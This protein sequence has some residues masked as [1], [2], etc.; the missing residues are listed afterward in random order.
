MNYRIDCFLREYEMTV[1]FFLL[2]VMWVLLT[3]I[4]AYSPFFDVKTVDATPAHWF[5]LAL[6]VMLLICAA[7]AYCFAVREHI[8]K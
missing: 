7:I 6:D 3:G 8:T 2:F 1:A 4:I 5:A